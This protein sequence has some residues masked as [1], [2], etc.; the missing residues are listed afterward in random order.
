MNPFN[1][2][3]NAEGLLFEQAT[4]PCCNEFKYFSAKHFS[5]IEVALH[6]SVFGDTATTIKPSS[7]FQGFSILLQPSSAFKAL[8][9]Y[10][11]MDKNKKSYNEISNM[12]YD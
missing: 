2:A 9:N 11:C 12:S 7:L 4:Q 5:N 10:N 8:N 1:R 3:L 6:C